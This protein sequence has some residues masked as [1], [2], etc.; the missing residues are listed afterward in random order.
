MKDADDRAQ[1]RHRILAGVGKVRP[2]VA[3]VVDAA[4]ALHQPPEQRQANQ[5]RE[6][7][8]LVLLLA[9]VVVCRGWTGV[10]W[11]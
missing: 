1:Q 6:R 3:R 10:S 11:R 2:L 8:V 9:P 7:N 5:N 4:Q